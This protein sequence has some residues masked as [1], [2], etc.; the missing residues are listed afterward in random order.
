MSITI[1][2][3]V[4]WKLVAIIIGCLAVS[5]ILTG[6]IAYSIGVK[7]AY[8]N[9]YNNIGNMGYS[10]G[11]Y[12]GYNDAKNVA[13][14]LSY[15]NGY[16]TGY[17]NGYST[18]RNLRIINT[19]LINPTIDGI[20]TQYEWILAD[21]YNIPKYFNVKNTDGISDGLAYMSLGMNSGR[22]HIAIDLPTMKTDYVDHDDWITVGINSANR[23]YDSNASFVSYL[24]NGVDVYTYDFKTQD[25]A[26]STT[27]YNP[28]NISKNVMLD[29]G[30]SNTI[31]FSSP[32]EGWNSDWNGITYANDNKM[33]F[34]QCRE[35]NATNPN[36]FQCTLNIT[37]DFNNLGLD[38]FDTFFMNI[39]PYV[40]RDPLGWWEDY[41][42]INDIE[43][44]ITNTSGNNKRV[45]M[46][47]SKLNTIDLIDLNVF[48]GSIANFNLSIWGYKIFG[49]S[50]KHY[51]GIDYLSF[52]VPFPKDQGI[53]YKNTL[54]N[55]QIKKAFMTSEL[56]SIPHRTIEISISFTNLELFV[57]QNYL[58]IFIQLSC[59]KNEIVQDN[60]MK[61]GIWF[62]TE[63]GDLLHWESYYS[64]KLGN[65]ITVV[66]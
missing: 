38:S 5:S 66:R 21:Y 25:I 29:L 14:N 23:I 19:G 50:F 44:M 17:Y 11:Y 10:N 24:N 49:E 59:M 26:K 1:I 42:P 41:Q 13:Y 62:G 4:N 3:Q 2:R 55:V 28:F 57:I 34:V 52:T 27:I 18:S 47:N 7:T 40:I 31:N 53:R 33:F 65:T 51:V 32:Y 63:N 58:R 64:F 35:D 61:R 30:V 15:P 6:I 37:I 60:Y 45:I 16:L 22:M 20:L 12:D 48:N 8:N 56:S 9:G 46:E 36:Y 39:Q 43:M 54:G